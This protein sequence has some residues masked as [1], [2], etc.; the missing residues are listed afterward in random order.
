VHYNPVKAKMTSSLEHYPWSSHHYFVNSSG[1]VWMDLTLVVSAIRRRTNLSYVEF[2]TVTHEGFPWKPSLRMTESE[3]IIIDDLVKNAYHES[4]RSSLSNTGFL[5]LEDVL[6][7]C[8]NFLDITLEQLKSLSRERIYSRKRALI[9]YYILRY[10]LARMTEVANLFNR[11]LS[12]LRRQ[13]LSIQKNSEK[14]FKKETLES[15]DNIL[16]SMQNAIRSERMKNPEKF[17]KSNKS[18]LT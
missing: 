16:Q 13:Y 2:M 12:A 18:C 17:N 1:P 5:S 15:I 14:H 11:D 9:A 10:S 7:V 6:S 8:L 3:N 4:M